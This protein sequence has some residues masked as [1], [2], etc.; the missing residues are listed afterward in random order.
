MSLLYGFIR[1]RKAAFS[2]SMR[3]KNHWNPQIN[4]MVSTATWNVV[5]S[6]MS[7]NLV[8]INLITVLLHSSRDK[9]LHRKY[10]KVVQLLCYTFCIFL[11]TIKKRTSSGMNFHYMSE[12]REGIFSEDSSLPC[13]HQGSESSGYAAPRSLPPSVYINYY[14]SQA[15]PCW[16]REGP[17][18][19]EEAGWGLR[20]L[21]RW[22][23]LLHAILQAP[24]FSNTDL[25][26]LID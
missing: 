4:H 19:W 14:C 21:L 18:L 20:R 1:A 12:L 11:G 24:C 7:Q 15:L 10:E 16:L 5:R 25:Q 8:D 3:D 6:A 23:L 13:S 17:P 2:A 26:L 9:L 22:L